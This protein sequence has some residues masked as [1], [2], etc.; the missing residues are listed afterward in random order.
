MEK[1]KTYL[2]SFPHYSAKVFEEVL[3]FLTIQN[4]E[5]G[6]F[7][8]PHGKV[9]KYV[10]FIETGLLR[11]YYLNDGKEVT[12]CF[13]RENTMTTSFRSMITQQESDIAIQAIEASRLIVLSYDSLQKLYE[14]NLFWQ[15]LGRLVV[16][17][18]YITTVKHNRFLSDLSATERYLQI[19]AH[20]QELLQRVPLNYLAT[21]L[22]LAPETLS[23]IRNKISRT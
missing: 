19:L 4:L 22:Q 16:E 5:A 1:F 8:L 21:Y 17:D 3:P 11:L 14:K 2:Q 12:H 10:G 9:C 13:C 20:D 15:Q 7:F 6:E 18:E 23:R